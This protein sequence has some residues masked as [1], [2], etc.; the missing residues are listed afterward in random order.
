MRIWNLAG[1]WR[2]RVDDGRLA[3]GGPPG[4]GANQEDS[5]ATEAK[6]TS[7]LTI[8]SSW[9]ALPG[10]GLWVVQQIAD[11]MH[12]L[13]GPDGTSAMVTFDLPRGKR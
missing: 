7:G 12:I 5:E 13:S 9:Q 1:A 3:C 10:H 2:C 8:R 11:Q 4:S 6:G